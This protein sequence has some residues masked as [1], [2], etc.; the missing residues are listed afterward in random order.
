MKTFSPPRISLGIAI[1]MMAVGAQ[2]VSA[3]TITTYTYT[4]NDFTSASAP[5]TT[6]DSVQGSFTIATL[7]DNLA[8]GQITP[9]SFSF[10]D[11]VTTYD[12]TGATVV[13]FYV[14]TGATGALV[15]WLIDLTDLGSD[16]SIEVGRYSEDYGD[17]EWVGGFATVVAA[18]G[19]PGVWGTVP[20]PS[21][22]VLI[23]TG[24]LALALL[25]RKRK[26]QGNRPT[27]Q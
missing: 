6:G 8:F 7:G 22:F 9:L 15:N 14:E 5:Y 25:A 21:T 24:L 13:D 20:E 1:L 11:G 2:R 17:G 26:I 12:Q 23:P 4:G 27:P 16:R 3:T 18:N 10:S 19:E